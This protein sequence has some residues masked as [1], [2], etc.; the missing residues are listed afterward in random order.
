MGISFDLDGFAHHAAI[1]P[2]FALHS[3]STFWTE[4]LC[5]LVI[6][7]PH[8]KH[9]GEAIENHAEPSTAIW[10]FDVT[11]SRAHIILDFAVIMGMID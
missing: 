3:L 7:M 2:S 1:A 4:G 9:A 8:R 10:G 5:T 11:R 6:K